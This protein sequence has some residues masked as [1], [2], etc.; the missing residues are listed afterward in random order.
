MDWQEELEKD[1]NDLLSSKVGKIAQVSKL[2]RETSNKISR[3]INTLKNLN[4]FQNQLD[5]LTPPEKVDFSLKE[6][7]LDFIKHHYD[8]IG[9][10]DIEF[11]KKK[12][13]NFKFGNIKKEQYTSLKGLNLNLHEQSIKNLN[14]A[15][16]QWELDEIDKIRKKY[17]D[18][19]KKKMEH[20]EKIRKYLENLSGETGYLWDMCM[21]DLIEADIKDIVLWSDYLSTNEQLKKLLEMIGRSV[22]QEI[23]KKKQLI[24]TEYF[25]PIVV[26]SL[27]S[28]EEI[29]NIEFGNDLMRVLPQE[30]LYLS[31][32]E[33]E[34]LFLKKYTEKTLLCYHL[35]GQDIEYKKMEKMKEISV[36]EVQKRGPIIICVDT[37]GSMQGTPETIAK[38][39]TLFLAINAIKEDRIC[40]IINFS[41]NIDTFVFDKNTGMRELMTFLKLSFYGGTDASPALEYAIQ[42]I[43]EKQF[44]KSDVLMISDFILDNMETET[45]GSIYECQKNGTKFY[46][47]NFGNSIKQLP[48]YLDKQWTYDAK[49]TSIIEIKRNIIDTKAVVD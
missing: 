8:A 10:S 32:P 35:E 34:I 38:A 26:D 19:F 11:Y 25:I 30:M 42:Q 43:K 16:S 3:R 6:S 45:L 15:K 40:Q 49:N 47:L 14:I 7:Q 17:W 39:T 28:K 48:K 1:K 29:K 31:E 20:L 23:L 13:K 18:D 12:Y 4:P 2:I 22:R 33:L 5:N 36:D 9:D 46:G 41:T 21:T 27:T 37:S 44:S 24:K